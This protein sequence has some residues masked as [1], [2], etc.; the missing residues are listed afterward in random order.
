M[1]TDESAAG[2][3]VLVSFHYETSRTI[4]RRW[5]KVKLFVDFRI[6]RNGDCSGTSIF[7]GHGAE[8][9]VSGW[10]STG[11]TRGEID[12]MLSWIWTL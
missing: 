3:R 12:C 7:S 8:R 2:V 9:L 5:N 6:G 11:F 10:N 1:Q 4:G